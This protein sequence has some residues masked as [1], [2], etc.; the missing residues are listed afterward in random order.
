MK[1]DTLNY[2][3]LQN[4]Y[5]EKALS[6]LEAVKKRVNGILE[7]SDVVIPDETIEIFC[8][9]AANITVIQYQPLTEIHV[10]PEKL[11]TFYPR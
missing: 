4:I 9:N 7:G 6:D 11:G 2:I 3:A 10:Q 5:R 8:K 1:S